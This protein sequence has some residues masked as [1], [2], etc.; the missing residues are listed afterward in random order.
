MLCRLINFVPYGN[1]IQ[2]HWLFRLIRLQRKLVIHSPA[3]AISFY[4]S[5]FISV[6]HM[7]I[8]HCLPF[9]VY[10]I[11]TLCL[12]AP[13]LS[14]RRRLNFLLHS[15]PFGFSEIAFLLVHMNSNGQ[16]IISFSF[17]LRHWISQ[18]VV[19]TSLLRHRRSWFELVKA[20]ISYLFFS[21]CSKSCSRVYDGMC[22]VCMKVKV[23][24]KRI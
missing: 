1:V 2:F 14:Q 9:I 12:V 19:A 18:C 15:V 23:A 20:R 8:S 4:R 6:C 21:S 16:V 24:N 13:L 22:F 7:P 17:V 5:L 11:L 10:V 3:L